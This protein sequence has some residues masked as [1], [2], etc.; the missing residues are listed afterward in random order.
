[1]K[2]L[3]TLARVSGYLLSPLTVIILLS[4]SAC[5]IQQPVEQQA[6]FPHYTRSKVP[7]PQNIPP[8]E[9]SG[10]LLYEILVAEFAENSGDLTLANNN[11]LR[12]AYQSKDPRLA[13]RATQAA[14]FAKDYRA[15]IIGAR[16]WVEF[17]PESLDAR[18]SNASLLLIQGRLEDAKPHLI[19][20][21]KND[22]YS[23]DRLVAVA[24]LMSRSPATVDAITLF[25]SINPT[26]NQS[27]ERIVDTLFATAVLAQMKSHD[28]IALKR[29]E[30]LLKIDPKHVDGIVQRAKLWFLKDR[31]KDALNS[32]STLLK[33]Q[34]DNFP[35]R[36][37][38]ARMLVSM[39][40]IKEGMEQF[41]EL[42]K[43]SP[44]NSD[45]IY[46]Y[47]ILAIQNGELDIAEAQFQNLIHLHL[48]EAE[49]R[50]SLGQIFEL[51]QQYDEAINWYRSVPKGEIFF[52][53]QLRAAQLIVNRDGLES[54]LSVLHQIP[55]ENKAEEL[56]KLV[57]EAE[58]L[59]SNQQYDK[60]FE[61]FSVAL[62]EAPNNPDLLYAHAMAAE[63]IDHIDILEKNL[64]QV[65]NID[66]NN[67]QALNALGYTLVD[68]TNR[69]AEAFEYIK[70][71]YAIDSKD[72]AILDSMG[73]AL[74]RL[75]RH[76]EALTYLRQASEHKDGE[77]YAHLGEVLW[78]SGDSATARAIWDAAI[79]FDP[80]HPVLKK[81]LE[82][83]A[84]QLEQ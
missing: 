68:R 56:Q 62:Q 15:A 19:W 50:Q 75:G 16:L 33:R 45:I 46:G 24:R 72:P 79:K 71:A 12:S 66:P 41:K 17:E 5:S 2:R 7:P 59:Q 65:L 81:T 9:L 37:N 39:Q 83:F 35:A 8:M 29:L 13:K 54:A 36:L 55:A 21:L 34:P 70:R 61:R 1:M 14:I 25:E 73:W 6:H 10:E 64:L 4:T 51:R 53:S 22:H 63:K 47:G 52:A 67:I 40:A 80:D 76:Q 42:T 26:T 60:A 57:T 49:A 28:E 74:Y 84:P 48:R 20:L 31:Q 38:Y 44:R 58:L 3:T 27:N 43:Q 77:I 18:Q 82:R 78:V 32:L 30:R 23:A 69:I 11:Y